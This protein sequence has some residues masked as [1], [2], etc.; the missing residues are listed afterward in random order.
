M[1]TYLCWYEHWIEIQT[2]IESRLRCI[3]IYGDHCFST[4]S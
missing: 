4:N 1:F 3:D 2:K